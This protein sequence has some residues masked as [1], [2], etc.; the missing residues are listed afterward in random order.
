MTDHIEESAYRLPR[1]CVLIATLVMIA[2]V[3][4]L[5]FTLPFL[6]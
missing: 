1:R 3:L 4:A 5:P 2:A 6:L